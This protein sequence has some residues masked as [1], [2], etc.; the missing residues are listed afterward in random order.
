MIK[1]NFLAKLFTYLFIYFL[2]I[3]NEKKNSETITSC[4]IFYL[5]FKKKKI[6]FEQI[7]AFIISLIINP[8]PATIYSTFFF[9]F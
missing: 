4:V 9:F 2:N 5:I 7:C 6:E 3:K 1:T 8:L